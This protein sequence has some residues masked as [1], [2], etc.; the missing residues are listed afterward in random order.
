MEPEYAPR[1]RAQSGSCSGHEEDEAAPSSPA[2]SDDGAPAVVRS[3]AGLLYSLDRLPR[4]SRARVRDALAEPPSTVALQRCR[5][6]GDT[7]P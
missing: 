2:G 5:R 7:R 1:A 6:I 4:P 3:P